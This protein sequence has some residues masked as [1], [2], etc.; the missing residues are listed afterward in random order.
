MAL[1]SR[2]FFVFRIEQFLESLVRVLLLQQITQILSAALQFAL[3]LQQRGAQPLHFVLQNKQ[4]LLSLRRRSRISKR[5]AALIVRHDLLQLTDPL[6][7]LQNL[8]SGGIHVHGGL[9]LD[10]SRLVGPAQRVDRLA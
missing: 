6:L 4:S 1:Q 10:L 5:T 7:Q 3:A 2:D 9:V 8:R